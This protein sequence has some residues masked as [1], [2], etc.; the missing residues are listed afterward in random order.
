[1]QYFETKWPRGRAAPEFEMERVMPYRTFANLLND[2]SGATTVEYG[3]VAILVSLALFL[4]LGSLGDAL[5][6][7]FGMVSGLTDAAAETV[8]AGDSRI[9]KSPR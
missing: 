4:V 7:S 3:L 5:A 1:M 6:K 9:T 8:A 2:E